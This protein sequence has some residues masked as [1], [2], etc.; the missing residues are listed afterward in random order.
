MEKKTTIC[1][2]ESFMWYL[3][4]NSLFFN[5]FNLQ[6]EVTATVLILNLRV[7]TVAKR[8]VRSSMF[9]AFFILVSCVKLP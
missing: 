2:R 1:W 9:T 7:R 5:V 6:G 3:S 4:S 8:H